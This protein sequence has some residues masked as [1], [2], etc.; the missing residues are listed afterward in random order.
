MSP[1][2]SGSFRYIRPEQ[3]P[4]VPE[5]Q[6]LLNSA[7][8][9]QG[10][11]TFASCWAGERWV[12]LQAVF[13]SHTLQKSTKYAFKTSETRQKGKSTP[14]GLNAETHSVYL[15]R[16]HNKA[17]YS[18]SI[19]KMWHCSLSEVGKCICQI[20]LLVLVLEVFSLMKL[21]NSP[22]SCASHPPSCTSGCF[23]PSSLRVMKLLH[24]GAPQWGE[25]K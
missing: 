3:L 9:V 25:D 12:T 23:L 21:K 24:F 16:N 11:V 17:E 13:T 20:N 1:H 6:F 2:R 14:A 10:A 7:S 15:E 4:E 5:A 18:G 19:D 8:C 22:Y